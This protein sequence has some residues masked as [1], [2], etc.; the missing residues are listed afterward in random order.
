MKL[1][2]A[3]PPQPV[4]TVHAH[5]SF[6]VAELSPDGKTIVSAGGDGTIKL[7]D[8]KTLSELV[9]LKGH[10]KRRGTYASFSAD[11][12]LVAAA[13]DDNTIELWDV[14]SRNELATLTGHSDTVV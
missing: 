2:D 10:T 12:K 7:W 6:C 14:T 8:V 5:G 13:S 11:G 1:W 9:T 3:D 4:T